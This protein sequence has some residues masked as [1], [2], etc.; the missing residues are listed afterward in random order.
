MPA[1]YNGQAYFVARRISILPKAKQRISLIAKP[2]FSPA[3]SLL[4]LR[5]HMH[6]HT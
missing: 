1:R 6:K 4:V 2:L 5:G 3:R